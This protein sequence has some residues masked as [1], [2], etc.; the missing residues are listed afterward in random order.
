MAN[1]SLF[2]VG[3]VVSIAGEHFMV[4]GFIYGP[5]RWRTKLSWWLRRIQQWVQEE[6]DADSV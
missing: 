3:S 1:A 2:I 4:T 5:P 6:D